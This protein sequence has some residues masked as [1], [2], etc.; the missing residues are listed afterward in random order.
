VTQSDNKGQ[1]TICAIDSIL[2]QGRL[3]LGKYMYRRDKVEMYRKHRYVC[4]G[5]LE[6][7]DRLVQYFLLKKGRIQRNNKHMKKNKCKTK[8]FD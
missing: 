7:R 4:I 8:N 2:R 6:R 5:E 1:G 3:R